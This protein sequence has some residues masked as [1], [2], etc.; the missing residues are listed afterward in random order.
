M[1]SCGFFQWGWERCCVPDCFIAWHG[2]SGES[3]W[4]A[5]SQDV[6]KTCQCNGAVLHK[7]S[8]FGGV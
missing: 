2:A 6:A 7:K 3:S 4:K 5:G 1:A 8:M